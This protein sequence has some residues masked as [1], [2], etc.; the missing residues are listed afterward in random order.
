VDRSHPSN[1]IDVVC[2]VGAS[3]CAVPLRHVVVTMR[4][5]P[6]ERLAGVPPFVLGVSVVRGRPTPVID[7]AALL[8]LGVDTPSPPSRFVLIHFDDRQAALAVDAVLGVQS[9]PSSP[10]A[11]LPPLLG[12]TS[13]DLLEAIGALDGGLFMV[14]RA[15]RLVPSVVWHVLGAHVGLA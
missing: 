8:G 10:A 2:R 1:D 6:V 9:L 4:P 13:A 15:A 11:Y 14:L 3:V 12:D 7:A 5:L